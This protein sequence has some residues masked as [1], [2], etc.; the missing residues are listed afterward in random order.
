M[1]G[2]ALCHQ[3]PVHLTLFLDV[4]RLKA[5]IYKGGQ[6]AVTNL[7]VVAR[8]LQYIVNCLLGFRDKPGA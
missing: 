3:C 7:A 4:A 1:L 6:H 5:G 2:I 8:Y